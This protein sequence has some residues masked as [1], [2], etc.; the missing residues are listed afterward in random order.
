MVMLRWLLLGLLL[1]GLGTGLRRG[2]L[3]VDSCRLMQDLHI[4][5][6]NDLQ[7]AATPVCPPPLPAA[8]QP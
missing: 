7:P 3:V 8:Q 6:L 1:F 5:T 2:W 4:P